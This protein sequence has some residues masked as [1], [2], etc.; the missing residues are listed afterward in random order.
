MYSNL[1]SEENQEEARP[2]TI[3]EAYSELTQEGFAIWMRLLVATDSQLDSGRK[4][5][6]KLLGYSEGRSNVI[7]R[8]LKHKGYIRFIPAHR[9]GLPTLVKIRRKALI[10]GPVRIIRLGRN[11]DHDS[12]SRN[13]KTSS[14]K[15]NSFKSCLQELPQHPESD[16]FAKT[17]AKSDNAGEVLPFL[18]ATVHEKPTKEKTQLL[19]NG[20]KPGVDTTHEK[21]KKKK[22]KKQKFLGL[23]G[24]YA[25]K[26]GK[27]PHRSKTTSQAKS[28]QPIDLNKLRVTKLKENKRRKSI[29]NSTAAKR[30]ARA[31]R[32]SPD[33]T[34][35]D[36]R[37]NPSIKFDCT[38]S[39]RR[40]YIATLDRKP[41][42]PNRRA[43]SSKIETE[44]CRIYTRYRREFDHLY[45]VYPR[46][47][48]YMKAFGEMCI[49]KGVTPSQ[50][51]AYWRVKIK[52]FADKGL[53]IVPP[54]F[55]KS[56]SNIDTAAIAVMAATKGGK[57]KYKGE[58]S[59]KEDK[60]RVHTY[61]DT[62]RL[63]AGIRPGLESAGFDLSAYTD[64]ALMSVQSPAK[65]IA[66]G[67]DT[68]ISSKI[69]P[70]AEWIA[71][72]I[73]MKDERYAK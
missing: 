6:S 55:L 59:F 57:L 17:L 71:E 21:P 33:I 31:K 65:D 48:D 52:S 70:M 15:S 23:D 38:E 72:N 62:S 29:G 22:K 8:E 19:E 9:P 1:E 42:S 73:L 20:V 53:H 10:S 34:K 63:H 2:A 3:P 58:V 68:F 7:L 35:L 27:N 56:P 50:V 30:K 46:E 44:T 16:D 24:G 40:E 51:L 47:R 12:V 18:R 61:S 43:L 39:K 41:Q 66:A 25:E 4:E 13:Q 32:K 67:R 49:R 45:E 54:S 69:R 37:G 28:S 5:V 64:R 36:L 60:A 14:A 26:L 11:V